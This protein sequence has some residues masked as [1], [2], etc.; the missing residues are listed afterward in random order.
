MQAVQPVPRN[1][2]L[3]MILI[4]VLAL[5]FVPTWFFE[6]KALSLQNTLFIIVVIEASYPIYSEM[7]RVFDKIKIAP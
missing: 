4:F 2:I 1:F 5:A 3:A 7:V 6:Y